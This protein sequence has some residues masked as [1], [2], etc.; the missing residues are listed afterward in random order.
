MT[1]NTAWQHSI[2]FGIEQQ[3]PPDGKPLQVPNACHVCIVFLSDSVPAYDPLTA[4]TSCS[5]PADSL[6]SG[7]WQSL[8]SMLL[9]VKIN[10]IRATDSRDSMACVSQESRG[11]SKT[12]S[13][14]ATFTCNVNPELDNHCSDQSR[15]LSLRVQST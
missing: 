11:A 8:L 9:Q 1:L 13:S 4:L 10:S 15:Y 7:A 3:L 14:P 2:V 12:P 6:K 5:Y